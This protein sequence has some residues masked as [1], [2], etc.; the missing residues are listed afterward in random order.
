MFSPGVRWL[1]VELRAR[2]TETKVNTRMTATPSI[3]REGSAAA[4][5]VRIRI[6]AFV[7]DA[8]SA[9]EDLPHH[10]SAA[11]LATPLGSMLAIADGMG[12]RL[13]EFADRPELI[14]EL[15]NL[16]RSLRSTIQFASNRWLVQLSDE[17]REYFAGTRAVFRTAVVTRGTDF[18]SS[19]WKE[20]LQIPYGETRSY[21]H[22]ATAI[23]KPSA[24]RAVGRANGKNCFAILVPCHRL[25]GSNGQ[26]TGYAGGLDRKRWLIDHE[27]EHK[28]LSS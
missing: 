2:L 10:L 18:E 16:R 20:L 12:V 1:G 8:A 24:V 7:R 23:G 11:W 26:L 13:L 14:T 25:I 6:E 28:C 4:N 27:L 19:V 22:I 15:E 21:R 5:A 17:M 9:G 3:W